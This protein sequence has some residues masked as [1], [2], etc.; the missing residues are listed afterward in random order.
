MKILLSAYACEP[1]KG[2][3][4]GVGWNVA[5]EL[6]RRH[7]LTVLTRAN[8][9][10]VVEACG[11]DWTK[12]VR[13]VWYDPPHWLTFWKKGGRGVQI[14]YLIWQIG[15]ARRILRAFRPAE[16]DLVHHVTFGKYWIPSFIHLPGVPLVFGPVGGGEE[17][18]SSFRGSFSLHG[19]ISETAK[20]VS[21]WLIPRFPGICSAY[22]RMALCLAATD[23][24]AVKL[25]RF[26]RCPVAVFPQSAISADDAA[27][28]RRIAAG[29]TKSPSPLF[30]TACRLDHW[31]AVGFAIAAFSVYLR[32]H[33][34][35][36]LEILGNGPE[37][38][39]LQRKVRRM[40]LSECVVFLGRL[41]TLQDVY[42]RMA[43]ATALL[44][45]ALHEAFG[46]SCLE[47]I[48]LGT[49]VVCWDWGGPGLICRRNGLPAVPVGRT[50]AE[51]IHAFCSRMEEFSRRRP[52]I[53][54]SG[55]FLW[56]SWCDS[57]CELLHSH[58]IVKENDL[59][60]NG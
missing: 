18:P 14:F 4:P 45:P 31:K 50:D 1:G 46:Q 27:A 3:E 40:G 48:T 42:G 5:K 17:T 19:R 56:D 21:S 23:Q 53:S 37:K 47:A 60:G 28:M 25:K 6:S 34:C 51:S 49:P 36:R 30:L 32:N 13:W 43:A 44:H 11:E 22:R 26:A 24:T 16:F 57:F 55:D 12:C 41:P 20:K 2:S 59:H 38:C 54:L 33:P 39:R 35:A 15:A 10:P 9:R 52:R 29:T 7:E 8:N 58:G